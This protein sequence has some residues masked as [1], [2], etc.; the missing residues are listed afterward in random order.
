MHCVLMQR[1]FGALFFT[2]FCLLC[3]CLWAAPGPPDVSWLHAAGTAE[4]QADGNWVI[5]MPDG[6]R[7]PYVDP[8]GQVHLL[9]DWLPS[10]QQQK[11]YVPEAFKQPPK[12]PN[13]PVLRPPV[14]TIIN[15]L[16]KVCGCLRRRAC[17]TPALTR[18][19]QAMASE[20]T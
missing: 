5:K 19:T 14:P 16:N 8:D 12:A 20:H 15:G 2:A 13:D 9:R 18:V 11:R 3:P 1:F 6:S 17:S 4:Q 7:L 10:Q